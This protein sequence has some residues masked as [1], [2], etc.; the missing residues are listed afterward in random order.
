MANH[1]RI[2]TLGPFR[3]AASAVF[4]AV[5][6]SACAL[7]PLFGADEQA[8]IPM[9][10]SIGPTITAAPRGAV[11]TVSLGES[12]PAQPAAAQPMAPRPVAS[13]TVLAP[14]PVQ[15]PT[16]P[17]VPA[18]TVIAAPT[19]PAAALVAPD[20]SAAPPLPPPTPMQR[21]DR[22]LIGQPTLPSLP[23]TVPTPQSKPSSLAAL[24]A[25]DETAPMP[26][27]RPNQG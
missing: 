15:T 6:L 2:G 23:F 7:P 3:A 18:A 17:P 21:G 8:A 5:L 12:L 24:D 19:P 22:P 11:E 14:A 10:E 4:G 27:T 9:E 26:P 16:Q 25:L 20:N 13:T 1:R